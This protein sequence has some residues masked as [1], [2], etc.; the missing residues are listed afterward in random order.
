MASKSFVH[1]FNWLKIFKI[2]RENLT[3]CY[4]VEMI[5]CCRYWN[6]LFFDSCCDLSTYFNH[7]LVMYVQKKVKIAFVLLMKHIEKWLWYWFRWWLWMPNYNLL[8]DLYYLYLLS[9]YVFANMFAIIFG[10][11]DDHIDRIMLYFQSKWLYH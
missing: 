1:R 11:K 3:A 8:C 2:C 10:S 7:R 5:E 9:S 6:E 4:M